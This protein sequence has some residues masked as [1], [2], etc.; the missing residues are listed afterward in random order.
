MAVVPDLEN[1]VRS[2]GQEL[3]TQHGQGPA[4]QPHNER[5]LSREFLVEILNYFAELVA[6]CFGGRQLRLVVHGGACMLLHPGLYALTQQFKLAGMAPAQSPEHDLSLRTF[7]RDV[8]YI[9]RSFVAEMQ[10][11]HIKDAEVNFKECIRLTAQ[12]FGLG[13]DWMNSDADISLPMAT[14][15]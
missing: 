14:N 12:R 15:A 10:S 9:H 1:V 11:L 5:E 13:A 4:I 3:F 6:V 2:K 7:T 8:D